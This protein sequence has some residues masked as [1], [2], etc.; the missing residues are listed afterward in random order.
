LYI[1]A[2]A[3]RIVPKIAASG[4]LHMPDAA[5]YNSRLT[6]SHRETGFFACGSKEADFFFV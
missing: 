5:D 3:Q 1:R 6:Q 2:Y 4:I